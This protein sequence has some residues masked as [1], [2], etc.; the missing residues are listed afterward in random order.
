MPALLPEDFST[1]C[2]PLDGFPQAELPQ[3][4][5]PFRQGY[6]LYSDGGMLAV[7]LPRHAPGHFGLLLPKTDRGAMFFVGDACWSLPDC[8]AGRMPSGLVLRMCG[9]PAEFRATY[10][11]LGELARREADR[12]LI[13][14]AH[15]AQT[16]AEV[17]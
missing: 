16:L 1:R 11:A 7:P 4:M 10:A 6:D 3:W 15:C 5:A 12:L 8:K 13:V 17:A 14:P 9:C 2:L